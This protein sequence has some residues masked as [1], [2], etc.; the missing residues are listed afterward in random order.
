MN[1][2]EDLKYY[3]DLGVRHFNVGMQLRILSNYWKQQGGEANTL[4]REA[5]LK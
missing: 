1:T 2:V 4:L 5:G 3:M